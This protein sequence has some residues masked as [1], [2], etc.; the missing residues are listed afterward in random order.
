V[1][2]GVRLHRVAAR[3]PFLDHRDRAVERA[4]PVDDAVVRLTHAVEVHVD[5][6]ALVRVAFCRSGRAAAFV[7]MIAC[8]FRSMTPSISSTISIDRRLAAADRD[9]R[10]T[11]RVD[12]IEAAL[13][14]HAVPEVAE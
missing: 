6:R 7:H 1:D 11:A 5:R 8:F 9:D 3:E 10:R 14:R 12:R 4:G 2:G 13:E